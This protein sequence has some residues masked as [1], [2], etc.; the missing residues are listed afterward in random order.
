MRFDDLNHPSN[1]SDFATDGKRFYF[2]IDDRQSNVFV[3]EVVQ[4]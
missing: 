3:A 1:R 2:A 4:K